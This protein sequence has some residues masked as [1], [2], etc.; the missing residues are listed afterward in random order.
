MSDQKPTLEYGRPR[1]WPWFLSAK[2][3]L[4]YFAVLFLVF[5][6]ALFYLLASLMNFDFARMR[7]VLFHGH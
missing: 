3:W 1:K 5:F 6:G 2:F 7:R 4:I